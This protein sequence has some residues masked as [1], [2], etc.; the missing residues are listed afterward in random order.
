[1]KKNIP[2]ILSKIKKSITVKTHIP[3]IEPKP[4]RQ[5]DMRDEARSMGSHQAEE[6]FGGEDAGPIR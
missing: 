4:Y 3:K 1:M 2:K 6:F 5:R